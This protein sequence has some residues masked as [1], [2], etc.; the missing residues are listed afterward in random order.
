MQGVAALANNIQRL[1]FDV[2]T[3]ATL[4]GNSPSPHEAFLKLA[5]MAKTGTN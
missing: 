2:V 1:R 3:H 4:H 5:A